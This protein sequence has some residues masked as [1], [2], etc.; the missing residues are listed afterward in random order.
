MRALLASVSGPTSAIGVPLAI[1]LIGVLVAIDL[2][3]ETG[4]TVTRRWGITA[5][6][7]A[8]ALFGVIVYRF[9]KIA[10]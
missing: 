2:R 4:K 1:I 8:A 6:L 9:G 3:S 7:L 10:G 5:L